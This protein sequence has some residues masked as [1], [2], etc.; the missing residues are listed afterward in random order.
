MPNLGRDFIEKLFEYQK[1]GVDWL[2][3]RKAALLADEMGLG[4]SAQTIA[5]ADALSL[6]RV[7]VV[8]PAVARVNWEREF[9][10]FSSLKRNFL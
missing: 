6:K 3:T 8:C 9:L 4:K 1:I 5:A 10:K 2:R 7:L